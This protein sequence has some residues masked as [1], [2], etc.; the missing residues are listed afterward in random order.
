MNEVMGGGKG[1]GGRLLRD[2][3]GFGFGDE[4]GMGARMLRAELRGKERL[5]SIR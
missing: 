1:G 5:E 3:V 4:G 2:R